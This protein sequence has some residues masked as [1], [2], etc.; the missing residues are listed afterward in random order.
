MQDLAIE[1]NKDEKT[2]KSDECFGFDTRH[3]DAVWSLLRLISILF[4]P[5]FSYH[6][7]LEW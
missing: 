3:G 4:H 1:V 7:I 5:V 6:D 2:Q